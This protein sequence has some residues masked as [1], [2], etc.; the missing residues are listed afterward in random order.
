MIKKLNYKGKKYPLRISYKALKG[1]VM[2]L[3]REFKSDD[4]VF[5]FEGAEE[6]LFQGIKAGC[7][8][9]G[10]DMDLKREDME[11]VLDE[12]FDDFIAA[13]VAFSQDAQRKANPGV[14]KK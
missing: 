9:S 8:F 12:C 5:D 13:F 14:R 10:N 1:V 3:G 11:N 4:E 7:E 6:L 2:A